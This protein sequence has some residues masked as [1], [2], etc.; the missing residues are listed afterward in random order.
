MLI[1]L[2]VFTIFMSR[3]HNIMEYIFK[4]CSTILAHSNYLLR[5]VYDGATMSYVRRK[6]FLV[7]LLDVRKYLLSSRFQRLK[8]SCFLF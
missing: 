7:L 4:T 2:Y 6:S 8:I 3:I 5:Q 1:K